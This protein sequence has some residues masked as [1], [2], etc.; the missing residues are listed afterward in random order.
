MTSRR[1]RTR[2]FPRRNLF[3]IDPVEDELVRDPG[4]AEN[5][6][7]S[8]T[9]LAPSCNPT[10]GP[11][12]VPVLISAPVF[13]LSLALPFSDELFKQFIKGYLE[14]QGPI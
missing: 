14:S 7:S 5:S 9:S 3:P 4:I 6:Y 2:H 8:S 10:P 11:A 12:L 13:A 1:S